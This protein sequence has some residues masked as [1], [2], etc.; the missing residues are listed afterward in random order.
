MAADVHPGL[1]LFGPVPA[2]VAFSWAPSPLWLS[3]QVKTVVVEGVVVC[4][5][6]RGSGSDHLSRFV[7][8]AGSYFFALH[9]NVFESVA[10]TISTCWASRPSRSGLP[11]LT[12]VSSALQTSC[13][14]R[15]TR[16]QLCS[17]SQARASE[18][19]WGGCL[20]PRLVRQLHMVRNSVVCL[21]AAVNVFC[22]L[23]S[24]HT[25]EYWLCT[26]AAESTLPGWL[27]G[28]LWLYSSW[29]SL[30][31]LSHWGELVSLAW[32]PPRKLLWLQGWCWVNALTWGN[33]LT[34]SGSVRVASLNRWHWLSSAVQ[35]IRWCFVVLG[36]R[37]LRFLDGMLTCESTK[38]LL[39]WRA[40][41]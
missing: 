24:S 16:F 1:L 27:F 23:K 7:R 22:A 8:Q 35:G 26:F 25:S 9:S 2:V 5:P 21:N 11:N 41:L 30:P 12:A 4:C 14:I 19:S 31:P 33:L 6:W 39:R 32:C 34:V 36:Y 10:S 28:A 13:P 38:S 17:L 29:Q 15:C 40:V 18:W 20:C 3:R 37:C